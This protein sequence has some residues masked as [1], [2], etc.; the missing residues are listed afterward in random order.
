MA[1]TSATG[2]P[3]SAVA[4]VARVGLGAVLMLAVLPYL[5]ALNAFW[6]ADDY[7][8]VVPKTLDTILNFFNPLNRAQYRPFNW[9]SWAFDYTLYHSQP[10][11]WHVTQLAM[12]VFCTL[13][14]VLLLRDLAAA[15]WPS[16]HAAQ[17]WVPLVTGALFAVH[18]SHPEAVTWI[19]GRADVPFGVGLF[20]AAWALTRWRT[21]GQAHYYLL[22]TVGTWLGLMGKEAGLVTPLALLLVDLAMPD[23]SHAAE[24]KA[25]RPGARGI[26]PAVG[27]LAAQM[28]VRVLLML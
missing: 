15:W 3:R 2:A 7:N 20:L 6:V 22:I 23:R 5:N 24:L 1:A 17:A 27:Y 26:A 19:G 28:S 11:G 13:M 16:D 21:T 4:P 10:I 9:L 14:I 12:H 8:Y 18:P 25:A